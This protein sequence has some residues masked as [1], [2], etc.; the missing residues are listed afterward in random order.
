MAGVICPCRFRCKAKDKADKKAAKD[1][2]RA[3]K[4][5]EKEDAADMRTAIKKIGDAIKDSMVICKRGGMWQVP[6]GGAS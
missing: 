4:Q 2:E 3:Q 6:P 1:A 5:Q